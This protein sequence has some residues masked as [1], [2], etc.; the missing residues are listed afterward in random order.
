MHFETLDVPL[1]SSLAI[2]FELYIKAEMGNK[3]I[4]PKKEIGPTVQDVEHSCL[5]HL[6]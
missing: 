6:R 5:N 4:Y 3:L 1:V 2:G